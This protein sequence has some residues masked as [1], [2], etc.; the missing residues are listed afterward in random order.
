MTGSGY[1]EPAEWYATLPTVHAAANVLLTD[2]AGRVLIV[3]PN[4][5]PGWSLPGGIMEAGERP[6]HCAARECQE[7]LSL[8]LPI[9]DLLIAGWVPP[10]GERLR[11]MIYFTFDAGTLDDPSTIRLQ[12]EELDAYAFLPGDEAAGRL[13]EAWAARIP[14]ALRARKDHRTVYLPAAS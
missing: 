7:E 8:A 14:A 2:S 1:L 12:E 5:R 6:D 4:Y 10:D 13:P 11:S 9:G 3:K